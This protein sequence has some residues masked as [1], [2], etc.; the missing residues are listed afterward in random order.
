MKK[1]TE[2]QLVE[3]SRNLKAIL[4]EDRP[5]SEHTP[6]NPGDTMSSQVG[7]AFTNAYAD[8][9]NNLGNLY[10][11]LRG[12]T[13]G[14]DK[15]IYNSID[16]S[17][18]K[19]DGYGNPTPITPKNSPE[20]I[21]GKKDGTPFYDDIK[22]DYFWIGKS[23]S[24]DGEHI[25]VGQLFHNEYGFTSPPNSN[26]FNNIQQPDTSE[27][28]ENYPNGTTALEVGTDRPVIWNN[29]QWEYVK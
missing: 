7:S 23:G 28:E 22:Q 13:H 12:R 16:G 21:E 17:Y 29:G 18:Y 8:V 4:K 27:Q 10:Q 14:P 5:S 9:Y 19:E 1:I 25:P 15:P 20:F 6:I 11:S 26:N 24:T 2:K 3:M